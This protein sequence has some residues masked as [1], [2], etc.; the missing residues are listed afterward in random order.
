MAQAVS[1]S[2]TNDP[3]QRKIGRYIVTGMLGSGAM[4]T[5]YRALDPLIERTVALKVLAIDMHTASES[6]FRERF[7]REAKSAG[8]LSHPNIVTIHDVGECNGT[9]YIAM[10]FLPGLTLRESLDSGV[11]L[12]VRKIIDIGMLVAR[13]LD[14][15]HQNG[16]IHRDI[17]PANIMLARSGTVKIMDFGIAIAS[18]TA[19]TMPDA[20]LGSPRYMAPEQILNAPVDART[21]VF[22]LGVVLYEMLA[23]KDPFEGGT[24]PGVMHKVLHVTPAPP[25]S[26]NP[27]VPS[28]LDAIV[29][30]AL[31]K[32]PEE[33]FQRAKDL[34]RALGAL[35]RELKSVPAR[36]PALPA[37]NDTA[38]TPPA[39]P[40]TPPRATAHAPPQDSAYPRTVRWG[41]VLV[42][43]AAILMIVTAVVRTG[44]RAPAVPAPLASTST[45]AAEQPPASTLGTPVQATEYS[46]GFYLGLPDPAQDRATDEAILVAWNA[47]QL[48]AAAR[49]STRAASKP[50]PARTPATVQLS[51][52]PW[53]EVHVDGKPRG[54][55][56][57]LNEIDL[58]PG[59]HRIEIR[60]TDFPPYTVN[61]RL[62][63]GESHRITHRFGQ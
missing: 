33:R 42:A 20:V 50:A 63:S 18:D 62:E 19:R 59:K 28:A 57:P 54:V 5:V 13:G 6:G 53:G 36:R 40:R 16:V 34:G 45:V 22:A 8:C 31:A 27:D 55:T 29:M 35:R 39:E 1:E 61:V 43:V 4:G 49:A 60:N 38:H 10:E 26:F 37:A 58:A 48:E 52:L 44:F 12:P 3:E 30:R 2:A 11:V 46:P 32:N 47:T 14:Y 56:P 24:I 23:G 7:F 51:V 41:G 17:K 9:P 25:T 15:A 21:D